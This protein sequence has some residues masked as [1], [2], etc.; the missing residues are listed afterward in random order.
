MTTVLDNIVAPLTA[1]LN[2]LTESLKQFDATH[3]IARKNMLAEI[4]PIKRMLAAAGKPVSTGRKMSEE[5]RTKISQAHLRLNREKKLA[6]S[7]PVVVEV[8]P[9]IAA[10]KVAPVKK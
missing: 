9:A 3:Q 5:A 4:E 2:K 6:A 1:E 7:A 10:K 8:K